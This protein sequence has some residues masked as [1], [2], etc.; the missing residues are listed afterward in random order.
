ME[1]PFFYPSAKVIAQIKARK[2]VI[3]LRYKILV[4]LE[5]SWER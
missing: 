4:F 5:L 3:K 1:N 2:T